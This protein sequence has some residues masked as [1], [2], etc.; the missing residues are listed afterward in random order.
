MNNIPVLI[1][2]KIEINVLLL[3]IEHEHTFVLDS[4]YIYLTRAKVILK[5]NTEINNSNFLRKK[6]SD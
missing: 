4:T 6:N 1:Q 2:N 5:K 3:I